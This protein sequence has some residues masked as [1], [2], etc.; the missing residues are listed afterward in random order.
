MK[1]TV[2]GMGYVGLVTGVC[3]SAQGNKVVL[4]DKEKHKIEMLQK[5]ELP[6]YEPGLQESL[7]Q[8]VS[9]GRLTFT[10]NIGEA[11]KQSDVIIIAVGTPSLPNGEADL[12]SVEEVANDIVFS[13][14][15]YKIIV[16]K[17]TVPVGTSHKIKQL[18]S[19]LTHHPFSIFSIPEFLSQ[20]SAIRDF[21]HPDRTIIGTDDDAGLER[22]VELHRPLTK[23]LVITDTRSAEMIKYASN[24]F[25]ATKISFINE[26]ANICEKVGADITMVSEGMGYD[27]RIGK[28]FLK[29]GIGYGGSCFPKDTKALIQIANSVDY[30]FE[31]LK[32]VINVNMEQRLGYIRKLIAELGTIEGRTIAIWGLAFKPGTDDVR[33]TPAAEIVKELIKSKAIIRAYDPMATKNFRKVINNETITWCANAMEALYDADAVFLLTEWEEF[34]NFDLSLLEKLMKQPILIDGRNMFS[35]EQLKGKAIK[36]YSVG[37]PQLKA[38]Q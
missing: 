35:N 32:C 3:F 27:H 38:E 9:K 6:F 13:I 29:A 28:S 4:V 11:V 36:Y 2:V 10:T 26:I 25:L 31:I 19:G 37:R 30:D 33:G 17:S 5:G 23:R 1:V 15:G 20:G 12:S 21:L 8:S 7:I 18:I 24:A 22:I 34:G 16:I 14:D